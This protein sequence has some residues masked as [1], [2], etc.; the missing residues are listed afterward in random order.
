M[1]KKVILFVSLGVV[2]IALLVAFLIARDDNKGKT[3]DEDTKTESQENLDDVDSSEEP[4]REGSKIDWDAGTQT[5][6]DASKGQ[7]TQK[8]PGAEEKQD[9]QENQGMNGGQ[10]SE[11]GDMVPRPN[12]EPGW[13]P[14]T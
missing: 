9:S 13:G 4:Y 11:E 10:E 14:I 2:L 7:E 3:P 1:K 12:T 6:Q 5:E 8:E